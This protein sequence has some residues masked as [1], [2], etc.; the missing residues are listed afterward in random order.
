[1]KVS[2]AGKGGRNTELALAFL[3]EIEGRPGAF[4]GVSFL[5][6]ATDGTDGPTDAAGAFAST[7]VLE[8]Y[9]SLRDSGEGIA[10]IREVLAENDS[11]PFFESLG[12]LLRTGP[13]NTNV[14]DI[15]ILLVE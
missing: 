12:R 5:S 14:C 9:R 1:V 2:G 13:T 10:S 3:L 6:G 8:R 4:A 11:Y 7:E 15:Q